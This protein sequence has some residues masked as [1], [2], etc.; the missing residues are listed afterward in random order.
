MFRPET[1]ALRQSLILQKVILQKNDA[2][3]KWMDKLCFHNFKE[4]LSQKIP[5]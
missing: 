4:L 1:A 3:K 2:N 5:K